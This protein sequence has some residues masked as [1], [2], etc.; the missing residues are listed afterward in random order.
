MWCSAMKGW[1]IQLHAMAVAGWQVC[2]PQHKQGGWCRAKGYSTRVQQGWPKGAAPHL[3]HVEGGEQHV[4]DH[5][6]AVLLGRRAPVRPRVE[7]LRQVVPQAGRA[8]RKRVPR[9]VAVQG[10]LHLVRLPAG[11]VVAA[12]PPLPRAAAVACVAVQGSARP[13]AAQGP[14][15]SGR[16]RVALLRAQGRGADALGGGANG[17]GHSAPLTELGR[18]QGLRAQRWG[19]PLGAWPL[20]APRT[21]SHGERVVRARRRGGGGGRSGGEASVWRLYLRRER[22]GRQAVE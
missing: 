20:P 4:L 1:S 3:F 18:R 15:R 10:P 11:P 2:R 16:L 17:A 9:G 19:L 7:L 13:V 21:G 6:E 8:G 12:P 22:R 14:L 5:A